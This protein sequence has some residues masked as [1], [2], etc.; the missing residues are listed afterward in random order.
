MNKYTGLEIAVIGMSI[1]CP[2]A[3]NLTDYWENLVEGKESIKHLTRE[4]LIERGISEEIIDSPN[5][6]NASGAMDDFES[7]DANFFNYLHNEA[8][9]LDPQTRLYHEITWEAL[10]DA[11]CNPDTY[12]GMIGMFIGVPLNA[13]WK[14]HSSLAKNDTGLSSYYIEILN[15]KDNLPMLISNKLNLQG[16]S[17]SMNTACSSSLVAVHQACRAILTGDCN[18]AVAGGVT[19]DSNIKAGYYYEDGLIFS[20]DGH[21]RPFDT[22]ANGTIFSE[23]AGAVVLKK[24]SDAIKDKDYIYGIIKGSAINNDGNRKLGYMSPSIDGQVECARKALIMSK[25]ESNSISYI[26]A[27]GTGTKLG[28][29]VELKALENAYKLSETKKC[30]IGS[31]KSNIG[32]LDV[33]S[34]AAGLIKVLLS[35]DKKKIPAS[36][37]FKKGNENI[38]FDK[39]PFYVNDKLKDWN[40]VDEMPLRAAI[41]AFGIGGTNAHIILEEAPNNV[42]SNSYDM[43]LFVFSAKTKK[44]LVDYLEKYIKYLSKDDS[45][46]LSN[47]AYSLAIGRKDFDYRLSLPCSNK[48]D[49]IEGLEKIIAKDL[50]LEPVLG[51]NSIVFMFSGQGSQYKTMGKEMYDNIPF[52]KLWMDKGLDLLESLYCDNF[53]KFIFS[54]SET[55]EFEDTKYVQPLLFVFE[56]AVAKYLMHLGIKPKYMIGHSVGEYVAAALSEVFSYE[57]GL[58]LMV[59]RGKLMSSLPKGSMLSVAINYEDVKD[60]LKEGLSIASINSPNQLVISGEVTKIDKLSRE[61]EDKGISNIKLRTSHAFHSEMMDPI[62]ENF[63]EV[64]KKINLKAPKIPFISNLTGEL[65]KIDEVTSEEYWLNHLRYTVKFSE[66]INTLIKLK[67]N[68][69]LELGPGKTLTSLLKQNTVNAKEYLAINMIANRDNSANS[70]FHFSEKIGKLWNN[71]VKVDWSVYYA[72]KEN[73]KVP[74]PSY[75]FEKTKYPVVVGDFQTIKENGIQN[76]KLEKKD[77]LD[78]FYIPS[79]K[80]KYLVKNEDVFFENYCVFFS[81]ESD[82][83]DELKNKFEKKGLHFLIVKKGNEFSKISNECYEINPNN[84]ADYSRLFLDLENRKI[85]SEHILYN[86]KS[87]EGVVCNDKINLDE[88]TLGFFYMQNILQSLKES[89][90]LKKCKIFLLSEALYNVINTENTSTEHAITSGLLKVISQEMP[91][92]FTCVVDVNLNDQSDLLTLS[93]CIY[94]EIKYN[95]FDKTVAIRNNV[96]WVQHIEDIQ[97]KKRNNT[98]IKENGVYLITGGLGHLGYTIANHLLEKY[99][100]NL[101]LIGRTELPSKIEL[102]NLLLEK[103]SKAYRLNE[104]SQKSGHVEYFCIDINNSDEFKTLM[105]SVE[106]RFGM[107]NGVIHTAGILH[108]DYFMH[109]DKIDIKKA[110]DQIAPKLYGTKTLHSYFKDKNPDF[111]WLSSSLSSFLGG[112]GIVSYCSGNIFMDSFVTKHSKDNPNWISVNLD[113]L[114]FSNQKESKSINKDELIEVFEVSVELE[115][116]TQVIVAKGNIQ[117]RF[118][119]YILDKIDIE[120]ASKKIEGSKVNRNTITNLYIEPSSSTEIKLLEIWSSFLNINNIGI[121]DDFFELGGDSLKGM[122]LLKLIMNEFGVKINLTELF[123]SPSIKTL[124]LKIDIELSLTKKIKEGEKSIII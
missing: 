86:W 54:P 23:G 78:S 115:G 67:A 65:V 57:E 95:D 20:P 120:P 93:E 100:A 111:I 122:A 10:E 114:N 35:L 97:I 84:K 30:A 79:W 108:S 44:S 8:I 31:V 28:D 33:A 77:I 48:K 12:Q 40:Q 92:V 18:V 32:H 121:G 96:R 73:R 39:S 80:K 99:N 63:R 36:I 62:L 118:K 124:A 71:G 66:G 70:V 58:T 107:I 103:D 119:K 51:E 90:Q 94:D 123:E 24:L 87:K 52:F 82:L 113:Y 69:F 88:N 98:K 76:I 27:H 75:A 41:S 7:F 64:L 50:V 105:T 81:E 56:Y 16:P 26:E 11:G 106:A 104:L 4:E 3:K 22:D 53:R 9:H 85:I 61:L 6:I 68:T 38:D 109:C 37:N 112:M 60:Y 34:G 42:T 1:R 116:I 5:Y 47:L 91:S 102:N 55:E 101:I 2:G 15:S 19:L 13:M 89:D 14:V 110:L 45:I 117:E 17:F 43:S 72:E 74:M 21:C 46:N 49:L 29:P 59:E 83:S 25:V